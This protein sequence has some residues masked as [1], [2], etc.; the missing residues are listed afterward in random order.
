MLLERLD[1]SAVALRD[2]DL[3]EDRIGLD[4]DTHR[5]PEVL[6]LELRGP[7]DVQEAVRLSQILVPPST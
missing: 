4:V 3:L 6:F 7:T 1:G 2:P 5:A